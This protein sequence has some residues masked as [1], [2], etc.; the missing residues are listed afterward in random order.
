M[1]KWW[2][3]ADYIETCNCAHG[4]PCNLT[5]IPTTADAA[6]WR[7]SAFAR[8]SA[9][10]CVSTASMSPLPSPGWPIIGARSRM[11]YID[12][13]ASAAQRAA[14]EKIATGEA[15]RADR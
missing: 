14:L 13:R 15:G 1:S 8:V 12:E 11:V 5:M 3:R 2:W 9:T 4:C 7:R 6:A 10:A